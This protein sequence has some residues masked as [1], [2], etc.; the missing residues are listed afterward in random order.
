MGTS[1]E[2]FGSS[3]RELLNLPEKKK[4]G[5]D[6]TGVSALKKAIVQAQFDEEKLYEMV[7]ERPGHAV[8]MAAYRDAVN[9]VH[10]LRKD[11]ADLREKHARTSTNK[12]KSIRTRGEAI[13]ELHRL[14]RVD[15]SQKNS[16]D[17]AYEK[18]L[19]EFVDNPTAR[20]KLFGLVPG[21]LNQQ[22]RQ[23]LA[24]YEKLHKINTDIRRV[25]QDDIRAE[26]STGYGD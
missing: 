12:R 5:G 20:Q 17:F 18:R 11:L 6:R 25:I 3:M 13:S 4:V 9:R 26:C 15:P 7:L 22:Q 2:E 14:S 21:Y 19:Q 16:S 24:E 10:R 1:T 23:K 8:Y